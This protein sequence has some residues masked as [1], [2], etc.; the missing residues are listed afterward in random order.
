MLVYIPGDIMGNPIVSC[1]E[2]VNN[3]SR[4][5]TMSTQDKHLLLVFEPLDESSIDDI[6]FKLI[7]DA[8]RELFTRSESFIATSFMAG[9]TSMVT[10]MITTFI[11]AYLEE[12]LN[13]ED[14]ALYKKE[15]LAS[16][17]MSF[18]SRNFDLL[19]SFSFGGGVVLGVKKK[20]VEPVVIMPYYFHDLSKS[21]AYIYMATSSI[22]NFNDRGVY[23]KIIIPSCET[24]KIMELD[25]KTKKVLITGSD[26]EIQQYFENERINTSVASLTFKD[27]ETLFRKRCK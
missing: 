27:R 22:E 21:N 3:K 10:Q 15:Y 26:L 20:L 18:Y 24:L 13:D 16:L 5:Y 17:I 23:D 14:Y 8:I 2:S 7:C 9:N 25:R 6:V 11:N 19:Q 1:V 12:R 4:V